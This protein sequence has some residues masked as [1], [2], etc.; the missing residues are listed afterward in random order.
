ML[1]RAPGWP[2]LGHVVY[3]SAWCAL[4]VWPAHRRFRRRLVI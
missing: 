3:L 4:G 2:A 1:G